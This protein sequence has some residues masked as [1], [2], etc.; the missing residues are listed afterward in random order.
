MESVKE[1]KTGLE[2]RLAVIFV[3]ADCI[4]LESLIGPIHGPD[5]LAPGRTLIEQV[6]WLGNQ[7][8]VYAHPGVG[9][10]CTGVAKQ[11]SLER[12][13]DGAY[14]RGRDGHLRPCAETVLKH[15]EIR[16]RSSRSCG[17]TL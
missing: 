2:F 7:I 17:Q 13:T 11:G 16:E 12:G 14:L 6:I 9:R 15:C 1:H 8:R 5:Q 3:A 4:F 10:P